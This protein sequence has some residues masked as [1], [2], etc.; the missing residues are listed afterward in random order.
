MPYAMLTDTNMYYEVVGTGEP[1]LLLPGLGATCRLIDPILA[2]L[3]HE[4]FCLIGVD[5]RGVGQSVARRPVHTLHDYVSDLV[6]LLDHLQIDRVHV[7][8][9]SLGGII[10]QRFA[11]D[12]P[13]RV[14][15]LVL[16]SCSHQFGPYLREMT[17][18]V[19]NMLRHF[20]RKYFARAMDMLSV[21][22]RYIDED[23]QRLD[24]H[25]ADYCNMNTS[26]STIVRQLRAL[27]ASDPKPG[28]YRLV[29]PTLV[30]AGEYDRLIPS[31][32]QRDMARAINQS[33][34]M[35]IRGGGH[36]PLLE[37]PEALIQ[38]ICRYLH[39]G[40]AVA[41]D[42]RFVIEALSHEQETAA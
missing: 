33:L 24:R 30:I 20:S 7:V 13:S 41:P 29:N 17:L 37:C 2:P 38:V 1:V 11:V 4:G 31:C 27:G 40:Q 22:P 25:V 15:R 16:I 18:L 23:P 21:G 10:A 42:S 36:N 19:G 28:E 32:Y 12:H 5:H 8:G 34:F 26:R 39:S 14:N 9:L 6:E 3:H 35:L